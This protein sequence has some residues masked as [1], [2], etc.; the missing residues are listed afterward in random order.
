MA[1]SSHFKDASN[2][3]LRPRLLISPF[4]MENSM[5]ATNVRP[6]QSKN[7]GGCREVVEEPKEYALRS[8]KLEA[9][10]L[11]SLTSYLYNAY[12]NHCVLGE[13]LAAEGHGGCSF[14]T[15]GSKTPFLFQSLFKLFDYFSHGRSSI[16]GFFHAVKAHLDHF[17]HGY[18]HKT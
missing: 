17:S 18:L 7:V 2:S 8:K 13:K 10:N 12:C 14:T 6:N 11:L 16:S 4:Q 9:L 3:L 5:Y 1:F 15:P